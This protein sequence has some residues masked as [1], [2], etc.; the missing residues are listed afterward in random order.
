MSYRGRSASPRVRFSRDDEAP[1]CRRISTRW[2]HGRRR[3]SRGRG[4]ARSGSSCSTGCRFFAGA[5]N[6]WTSIRIHSWSCRAAA[7]RRGI[8]RLP[9]ATPTSSTTSARGPVV[10]FSTGLNIDDHGGVRVDEYGVRHLPEGI[11]PSRNLQVQSAIV[12]RAEAFVG[13]YGGF[14]YMAPFYGVKSVAFYSDPNGFSRKHLDMARSAFD[15]IDGSGMLD[16]RDM[17]MGSEVI[18]R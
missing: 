6:G 13:T 2:W 11:A 7:P 18:Q 4:S 16:V 17:K 8:A 12:A 14:S 15:T 10:A 9:R 1:R 5:P 3:S